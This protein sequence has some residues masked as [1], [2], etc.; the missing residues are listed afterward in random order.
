M[1]GEQRSIEIQIENA[2]A[3]GEKPVIAVQGFNIDK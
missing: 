1:P 2:D 3:R